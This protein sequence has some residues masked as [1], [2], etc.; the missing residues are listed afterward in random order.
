MLIANA[1]TKTLTR[2]WERYFYN[3]FSCPSI[4]IITELIVL[5][6]IVAI[7]GSNPLK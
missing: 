1:G 3:N 7:G 6:R 2:T 4:L 5:L